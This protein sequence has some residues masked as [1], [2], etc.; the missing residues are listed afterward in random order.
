MTQIEAARSKRPDR[1]G[2]ISRLGIRLEAALQINHQINRREYCKHDRVC[3]I[4]ALLIM[5]KLHHN[6]I[7]QRIQ[8]QAQERAL[9]LLLCMDQRHSMRHLMRHSSLGAG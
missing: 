6:E 5:A 8:A 7:S 9:F 1:S 4:E 2:Q 3:L